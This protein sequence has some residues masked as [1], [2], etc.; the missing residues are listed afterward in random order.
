M[1]PD[2][3]SMPRRP[4]SVLIL[5]YTSD[6]QVLTLRRRRPFDFWQSVTGSLEAGE[7]HGDAARRELLEETGLDAQDA[8]QYR[9][10]SRVFVI[11]PRWRHRYP[12]GVLE[13]VEFEW[14]LELPQ[15]RAITLDRSEHSQAEWLPVAEA[16]ERVWSWTNK[17]A[18]QQLAV[19]MDWELP[20][21]T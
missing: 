20:R 12:P 18:L 3:D 13:N 5:I 19:E 15:A 4:L 14:R 21:S 11:D 7:D 10:V 6:A 8:L 16:I 2:P 9:G 17:E 1:T